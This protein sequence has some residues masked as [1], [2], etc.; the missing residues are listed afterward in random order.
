MKWCRFNQKGVQIGAHLMTKWP[1][2][3]AAFTLIG[4]QNF[5][6]ATEC[7]VGRDGR[8]AGLDKCKGLSSRYIM[9]CFAADYFLDHH[10]KKKSL[11]ITY[12]PGVA[13]SSVADESAIVNST[14]LS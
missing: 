8:Q 13:F 2:R 1:H 5:G 7:R 10:S 9:K 14:I 12:C 3:T 11:S 4:L 6:T